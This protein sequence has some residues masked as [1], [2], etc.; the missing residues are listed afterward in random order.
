MSV[1]NGKGTGEGGD[2]HYTT[3]SKIYKNIKKFC[4]KINKYI[5]H[6][7]FPP[8]FLRIPTRLS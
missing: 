4:K 2:D 6:K 5:V 1:T 8:T 7:F 3:I